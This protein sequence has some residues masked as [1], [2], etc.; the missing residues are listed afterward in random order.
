MVAWGGVKGM[1]PPGGTVLQRSG[2]P[3]AGGA[4]AHALQ[5]PAVSAV[6]GQ[7]LVM[8]SKQWVGLHEHMSH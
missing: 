7:C 4:P 5:S 2:V 1:R 6:K 8:K 3:T